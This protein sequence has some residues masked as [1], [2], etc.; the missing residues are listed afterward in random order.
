MKLRIFISSVL[1]VVIGLESSGCGPYNSL[2]KNPLKFHFYQEET[3]GNLSRSYNDEN[4]KLWKKLSDPELPDEEIEDAVYNSSL[5]DLKSAFEGGTTHNRFLLW[6]IR[7]KRKDI[8]EFLLMA[9]ELE[10]LRS[11]RASAWYHPSYKSK[12]KED[13]RFHTILSKCK[14]HL[15][16]RLADRYLLQAIRALISLGEYQEAIGI[17][18]KK[19]QSYPENNL[20]KRMSKRYVA[21]CLQRIGNIEESNRMFAEVGDFNSMVGDKENDYC[22][23][24]YVSPESPELKISLNRVIGYG[25]SVVNNRYYY[26][27]EAALKSPHVV[28]I[29]DWLFLKAYVEGIYNHNSW[30]AVHLVKQAL[31]SKFSTDEM[32]NDAKFFKIC[33]D[34]ENGNLSNLQEN[35]SWILNTYGNR[36]GLWFYI[37]PALLKKGRTTEALLLANCRSGN[38]DA[39]ADT[40]FQMMLSCKAKDIVAYKKYLD[41]NNSEFFKSFM[42]W[43][44]SDKNYLDEI[45]VTTFL[46]EG[47]YENAVKYLADVSLT[48]Q[49]L[50]SIYTE[51]FLIYDPWQYTY[52]DE[53]K[54]YYRWWRDEEE[55]QNDDEEGEVYRP[56]FEKAKN[57][58]LVTQDNEKL[59]FAREMARL[60]KIMKTGKT[61]DERMLAKLKY[62]IKYTI[63]RYN[64]FNFCWALTQYWLGNTDHRNCQLFYYGW[65]DVYELDH[66]IDLPHEL[67]QVSL[68][69]RE[70]LDNVFK[71]LQSNEAKAEAHLML[72][73]FKTIAKH[74]PQSAAGKYVS[75]H[76]DGWKDWL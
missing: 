40:G 9:K 2:T 68:T 10:E 28:N 65:D 56:I 46:G 60:S 24:A 73:N 20:F 75:A 41:T 23:M 67:A 74:Y 42:N 54:W 64:S 76:C 50:L 71:E 17:Y 7:N 55:T 61:K 3:I 4:V 53:D 31:K 33:I 6:I 48:Y 70:D 66:I 12:E 8:E 51:E 21:R 18:K 5:K 16:G 32:R 36:D 49:K 72:R 27:A 26:V 13:E 14:E 29:G 34:A 58:R 63:G 35:V 59:K 22:Y 15:S 30:R 25:D 47:D 45:I 11:E 44:I 19:F 43:V 52:T 1:L 57:K 38:Y 69:F 39:F 62:T 37:I